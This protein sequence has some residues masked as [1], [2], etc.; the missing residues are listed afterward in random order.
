MKP[1]LDLIG[2]WE[3][4]CPSES[5]GSNIVSHLLPLEEENYIHIFPP[6]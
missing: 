3:S 5:R 6:P 2:E 4:A 1:V